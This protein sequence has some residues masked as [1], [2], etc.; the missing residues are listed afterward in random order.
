MTVAARQKQRKENVS[1]A[2]LR[3]RKKA[4]AAVRAANVPPDSGAPTTAS[5]AAE[6]MVATDRGASEASE[7]SEVLATTRGFNKGREDA[8]EGCRI[9]TFNKTESQTRCASCTLDRARVVI[10]KV[11]S[12]TVNDVAIG[13]S[14]ATTDGVVTATDTASSVTDCA[15]TATDQLYYPISGEYYTGRDITL[16]SKLVTTVEVWQVA[17]LNNRRDGPMGVEYQVLWGHPDRSCNK[18]YIR[19]WEPRSKLMEDGFEE[20]ID[21][22]DHWKALEVPLFETFRREDGMD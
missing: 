3:V 15:T 7:T 2:K 20:E 17:Y 5:E 13:E 1:A 6:D 14:S 22:V 18:L 10:D 19:S 12:D 4:R 11:T 21:L 8:T 9:C 16:D